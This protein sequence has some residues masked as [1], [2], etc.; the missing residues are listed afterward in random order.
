MSPAPLTLHGP[1]AESVVA[2]VSR[3]RSLHQ[4]R[5]RDDTP[6]RSVRELVRFVCDHHDR[7][8]AVRRHHPPTAR[9]G[10]SGGQAI[11][12]DASRR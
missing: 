3:A 7:V 10:V 9:S 2:Q 4:I 6:E 1:N 5:I 8:H 12:P 11:T